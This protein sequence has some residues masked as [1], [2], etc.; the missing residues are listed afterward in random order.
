[1][2]YSK[3]GN[4][5]TTQNQ[6]KQDIEKLQETAFYKKLKDAQH[7][8]TRE[9][10]RSDDIS[11]RNIKLAYHDEKN[12]SSDPWFGDKFNGIRWDGVCTF[13]N[14]DY[15]N[16]RHNRPNLI[17][18][19]YRRLLVRLA[20]ECMMKGCSIK[21]SDYESAKSLYAFHLHHINNGK[22]I[23]SWDIMRDIDKM[24]E[25]VKKN[26]VV[27]C[28]GCHNFKEQDNV[29]SI[30]LNKLQN[31]LIYHEDDEHVTG[32][33]LVMD[34]DLIVVILKLF[35]MGGFR[36]GSVTRCTPDILRSIFYDHFGILFDDTVDFDVDDMFNNLTDRDDCKL[37]INSA[38]L[39]ALKKRSK[40][41][42]DPK[43]TKRFMNISS[44]HSTVIHWDHTVD[45]K[46]EGAHLNHKQIVVLLNEVGRYLRATCAFC[47]G[48]Q[49][50]SCKERR[51][52]GT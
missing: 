37:L 39:G 15:I 43:C 49:P 29:F 19:L 44:F 3:G 7:N 5:K 42:A 32:R 14:E 34:F 51:T 20:I 17:G 16:A 21:P 4:I 46:Y 25:E 45:K 28:A 27:F 47:H 18:E 30:P 36:Y 52:W 2:F 40:R 6:Y 50:R 12:N 8:N 13:T 35:V 41:C 9:E 33:Q 31:Q 24:S 23:S 1:L 10:L 48:E 22:P 38:I 11:F 26:C